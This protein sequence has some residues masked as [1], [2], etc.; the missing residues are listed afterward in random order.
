LIRRCATRRVW[1]P[2]RQTMRIFKPTSRSC[3]VQ[4]G[5]S[6][7][8]TTAW[9]I[10]L[11]RISVSAQNH[12][13]GDEFELRRTGTNLVRPR[14]RSLHPRYKDVGPADFALSRQLVLAVVSAISKLG[15]SRQISH[16]SIRYPGRGCAR[17]S[18]G[19]HP[20]GSACRP[21]AG[22]TS[23][24]APAARARAETPSRRRSW[25]TAPTRA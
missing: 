13:T 23:A 3:G 2:S 16:P 17:N 7:A 1:R 4:S 14:S 18:T 20:P 25:R 5:G 19:R 21:R 10:G 9:R 24:Q 12:P 15:F 8:E 22:P 6:R 11:R